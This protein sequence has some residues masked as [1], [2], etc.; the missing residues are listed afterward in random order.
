MAKYPSNSSNSSSSCSSNNSSSSCRPQQ[1]QWAWVC[2]HN[3]PERLSIPYWYG[4]L[5][6]LVIHCCLALSLSHKR[7][8][9]SHN[10]YFCKT[11]PDFVCHT[12]SGGEGGGAMGSNTTKTPLQTHTHT[13]LVYTL[14]EMQLDIHI[15]KKIQNKTK[16]KWKSHNNFSYL[17]AAILLA[18]SVKWVNYIIFHTFFSVKQ[19]TANTLQNSKLQNKN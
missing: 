8:K 14:K 1:Q 19:L 6:L 2:Q 9:Y 13:S 18:I 7:L 4:N 16:Q 3:K 17:R 15:E 11:R 5:L 10:N 12:N